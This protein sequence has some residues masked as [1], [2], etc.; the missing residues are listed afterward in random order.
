MRQIYLVDEVGATFFFDYRHS[1]L[2]SDI[3]GLGINR[4]NSYLQY[5]DTFTLAKKSNPINQIQGTLTFLQGYT[6][7]SKFLNYLRRRVGKLRLFYSSDNTKYCY[8][9]VV[10]LTKTELQYGVIQSSIVFDK[11]TMWLDR[12]VY[13][14]S[15]NEN[16]SNKVFPFKYPFTYS[17]S[18]NGEISVINGGC[19]P[20]PIRVEIT[21]RVKNPRIEILRDG[22]VVSVLQLFI[23]TT[24]ID[25]IITIEA[26]VTNQEM[27]LIEDGVKTDIYQY[28]DFSVDNFLYLGVGTH[29][30]HFSPGV[31]EMTKCKIAYI[32][33]YEGN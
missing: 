9:E 31:S 7:Y 3:G 6:G 28:Q 23:T 5:S 24:K 26:E 22:L 10:C 2:I 27:S 30:I 4:S 1:T 32:E 17:I 33:Q 16:K 15:V 14:I 11:L 18:F 25:S 19:E 20:A 13:T 21:G 29:T 8:V 12:K